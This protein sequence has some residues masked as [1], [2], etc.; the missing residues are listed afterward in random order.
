[1]LYLLYLAVTGFWNHLL[2]LLRKYW[3][4]INSIMYISCLYEGISILDE[5]TFKF[6]AKLD[7]Q[8][9]KWY[10][11]KEQSRI[12]VFVCQT[13]QEKE[14]VFIWQHYL[15]HCLKIWWKTW[16]SSTPTFGPT[17][18]YAS[19]SDNL[20]HKFSLSCGSASLSSAS[21]KANIFSLGTQAFSTVRARWKI[22]KSTP[23]SWL[24]MWRPWSMKTLAI[25][26]RK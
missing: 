23:K 7:A 11:R 4:V 9:D 18:R 25:R 1:M 20:R 26:W 10:H 19:F 8:K 5:T 16:L 6:I 21:S 2:F 15:W 24:H 12:H 13:S 22:I 17:S 14:L 3:Q